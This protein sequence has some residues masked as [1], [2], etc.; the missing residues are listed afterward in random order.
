MNHET[1]FENFE[2]LIDAPNSVEE[3]RELILQLAVK[4]KLVPQDPNEETASVLLEKII[5]DKKRLIKEKKFKKSQT[6]PEIKK[7]EIPFDIPKTWKWIRLNDVGDWGAGSTPDRKKSDYYEGSILWFKSGELNN[8]YINDSKEKI[9]DSALND[10]SLRLN[11]PDDVLIAMYGATIG[12]V[13]ILEVEATTN[14]AVC[15]CTCFLGIYNCY[16]FYLLKAYRRN[17]SNQGAGGAQPNISRHKIIHTVA[18]LPPYEEQQRIVAKVDQLMALCDQL[19]DRQ[20]KKYEQRIHLN[21]A[22][23]D[24]LLTAPTPEE[25]AQHWQRICDD[26][27]LLYD[28]PETVG[29]LRQAILQ[30]AVQGKLVPQDERDEPASVLLEKA[31]TD[32]ERLIKEKKIKR[33]KPSL[34][35]GPQDL[36]YKLPGKWE[37]TRLLDICEFI[38]DGTHQTPKY[39]EDGRIFLSAQ[40]IKPFRF[41]PEFHRFVSEEDYQGYIKN[42]KPEYEDIL[43]TRVGAGIGEAAVI[44]KKIDFAIYVS[45]ALIRP[46]KKYID[47][48]YLTIWLNSPIGTK[49]SSKNT[50]GKG[51]SQGNLNLGLINNFVVSI[52]PLNEQKRIVARVDQLIALC[53]ELEAG[54]AQAQTEAGKLME[55]VVHHVLAA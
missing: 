44:D 29:Q 19:E 47:S 6:L 35:I 27:N 17:F 22:V 38:T 20:Q 8:G 53:D 28:A 43:L 5:T 10:C 48:N 40:N 30:L 9:T 37:W 31:K 16:L 18:P 52:P 14:Q 41:M 51:V 39:T 13:A 23:L 24:K 15:A 25:F 36:E 2:L 1:F 49:K 26:F 54:L 46:F 50:Y 33:K 34:P 42:R 21:N 11:K 55:A 12:K 3:L 45:V 4:G 32:K 7:D